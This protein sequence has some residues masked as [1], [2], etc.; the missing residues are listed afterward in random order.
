MVAT[1]EN[2][3]ICYCKNEEGNTHA[4]SRESVIVV[5][6]KPPEQLRPVS[7]ARHSLYTNIRY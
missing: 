3:V 2:V 1:T 5:I 7:Y 4:S 6:K